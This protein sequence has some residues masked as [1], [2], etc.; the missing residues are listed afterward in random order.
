MDKKIVTGLG[1]DIDSAILEL[2]KNYDRR[3]IEWFGG[4][5]DGEVGGFYYSGTA[6]DYEGFLPDCESTCQALG[7]LGAV[8]DVSEWDGGLLKALPAS[9]LEGIGRFFSSLEDEDG[10]FYHPQ[11]GKGIGS[12]RRG[13]DIDWITGFARAN[14][15]KL[16][17]PTAYERLSG[18]AG[19]GKA[20]LPS[21][22]VSKENFIKY[23]DELDIESHPHNKGHALNSQH[24]QIKSAGLCD[25]LFD[26]VDALQE[27][28]QQRLIARGEKPNGLLGEKANYI[29]ISGLF[30]IGAIYNAQGRAFKYAEEMIDS[31]IKA[32]LS[33]E[34]PEVVIYVFNPWSGLTAAV[35]NMEMVNKSAPGTYDMEAVYAKIR[36]AAPEMIHKT[37]KKLSAFKTPDGAFSFCIGK[38]APYTQGVHVSLGIHEGEVNGTVLAV[39][40]VTRSVFQCLGVKRPPLFSSDDVRRLAEIISDFKPREKKPVPAEYRDDPAIWGK[41]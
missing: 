31:G 41:K 5:W 23:L 20:G 13:R 34:V 1:E 7:C 26:Y 25:T 33:D 19:E 3:L 8:C 22:L 17:Y 14:G 6:R 9:V 2:Y 39:N 10:Y 11:W 21:H 30:K 4:L 29:T 32:I 28:I 38:A 35:Q 40:G 15:I 18:S 37:A 27:K 12:S 36:A 24:G 16:P